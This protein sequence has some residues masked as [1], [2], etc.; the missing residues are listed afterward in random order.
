MTWSTALSCNDQWYSA[1]QLAL[2]V[3][4]HLGLTDRDKDA[5]DSD[6]ND[7]FAA[8]KLDPNEATSHSESVGNTSG[9]RRDRDTGGTDIDRAAEYMRGQI[10]LRLYR[11][12]PSWGLILDGPPT[13]LVSPSHISISLS[14]RCMSRRAASI[15]LLSDLIAF[16]AVAGIDRARTGRGV[17]CTCLAALLCTDEPGLGGGTV[18]VNLRTSVY[19]CALG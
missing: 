14:S 4:T 19:D 17:R 8:H 11:L 15:A 6:A 2:G 5:R 12:L 16:A 1:H 7:P 3:E 9:K 13:L 10:K 18:A